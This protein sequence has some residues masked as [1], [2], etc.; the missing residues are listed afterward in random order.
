MALLS[1]GAALETLGGV[2]G[3]GLAQFAGDG[4][5]RADLGAGR[6][7]AALFGIDAVLQQRLAVMRGADV[8]LDVAMYS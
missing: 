2:D 7:A 8:I 6:A 4:F 1:A 5:R 3:E